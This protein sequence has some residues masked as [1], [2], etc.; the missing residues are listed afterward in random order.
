MQLTQTIAEINVD[1]GEEAFYWGWI[2]V[3]SV[4]WVVMYI[5]ARQEIKQAPHTM[6]RSSCHFFPLL[7][8]PPQ[9]N[10]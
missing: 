10:A 9:D 7:P 4:A 8:P 1:K 5:Q 2:N 3:R 6:L